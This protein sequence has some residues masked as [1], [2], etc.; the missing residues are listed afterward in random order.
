MR[1]FDKKS[2]I[3]ILEEAAFFLSLDGKVG[4]KIMEIIFD[5][6]SR[7]VEVGGRGLLER[8]FFVL[9]RKKRKWE[10]LNSCNLIVR[11]LTIEDWV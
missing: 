1:A 6:R 11:L 8:F 10:R 2:L 9:L 5:N 7:Y 3:R 4:L